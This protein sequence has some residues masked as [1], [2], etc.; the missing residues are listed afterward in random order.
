ME[1]VLKSFEWSS[2]PLEFGY[3]MVVK[4]FLLSLYKL[5][6]IFSGKFR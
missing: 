1:K 5:W 6:E 4:L 3:S 2:A